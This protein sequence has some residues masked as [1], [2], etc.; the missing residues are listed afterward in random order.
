MNH[1]IFEWTQTACAH[2]RFKPDRAPVGAELTNHYIDCRDC[3]IRG[4]MARQQAERVALEALGD[5][6]ETGRLLNKMHKPYLGWFW[7]FS[8]W[9]VTL[10]TFLFLMGVFRYPVK[11]AIQYYFYGWP[12]F[13]GAEEKGVDLTSLK[14]FYN[15]ENQERE[16][17]RV[18][19]VCTQTAQAGDY[20]VSVERAVRWQSWYEEEGTRHIYDGF[21]FILKAEA[22]SLTLDGP[23]A[24]LNYLSLRDN[25]GNEYV[26]R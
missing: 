23:D 7:V 21:R 18:Y 20:T 15:G 14:P 12:T 17:F 4:G 26:N 9:A 10:T 6:D 3:L 8:R 5:P 22:D 13:F 16:W 25:M 19:G 2:I 24:I 1:T 11:D